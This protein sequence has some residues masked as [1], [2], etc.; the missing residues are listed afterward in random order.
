M[1]LSRQLALGLIFV[2]C[3]RFCAVAFAAQP[4]APVAVSPKPVSPTAVLPIAF[5]GWEVK[6]V[7]ARSDDPA[8]ADAVNAAVLKEYGF[9][10]LERGAYTRDDGRNLVIKA[11]VFEDAS[12]AYGA[13][14]YYYSAEMGEETIGGVVI[15]E[16]AI[17]AARIFKN[18]SFDHEIAAVVA[19]VGPSLQ[20][21]EAVLLKDGCIHRIGG[22]RIVTPGD[23]AF[24]LPAGKRYGKDRGRRD[25]LRR[26]SYRCRRLSSKGHGANTPAKNKYQSESKLSR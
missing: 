24:H 20:T 21:L 13:F 17:S 11:A 7:V 9:Q 16:G 12:G 1:K 18:S 5:S 23:D 26:N 10:R 8:A 4:P 22:G 6:G 25:R 3:G 2:F 14:T 19:S 15:G